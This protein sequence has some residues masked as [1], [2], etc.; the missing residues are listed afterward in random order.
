MRDGIRDHL[1]EQ[2]V[3]RGNVKINLGCG[4]K[5][6][7]GY[8]N[9]D[10]CE[11]LGVDLVHDLRR[12]L[13]LRD[14]IADEIHAQHVVEH[15]S[16][17]EWPVILAD[18]TRVLKAGGRLV[19]ECPDVMRVCEAF[20][21]DK[22]GL[23]WHWWHAALFGE[24]GDGMRHQQGFTIPR[25]REELEAAGYTIE[26]CRNWSDEKFASR[27]EYNIRCEAVKR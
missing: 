17:T 27:D 19:I 21:A 5:F 10:M 26:R 13:P 16:R 15:F 7:D 4:S 24:D 18:W 11:R 22:L 1:H 3:P 25:L 9:V 6:L 20:I 2:L 8:I 14:G 12:P 23:R